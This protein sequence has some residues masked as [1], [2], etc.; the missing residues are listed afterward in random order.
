MRFGL[1]RPRQS[2]DE[3]STLILEREIRLNENS[4]LWR[5][6]VFVLLNKIADPAVFNM[7]L[8]HGSTPL[9]RQ[10]LILT[11]CMTAQV[12]S[13]NLVLTIE[14]LTY[15]HEHVLSIEL[16]TYILVK[17]PHEERGMDRVRVRIH[18]LINM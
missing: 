13:N 7:W 14:L 2:A 17:S 9:S 16:L 4:V 10:K 11:S 15:T 18:A 1:H 3:V 6:V 8:Y 5:W 12:L